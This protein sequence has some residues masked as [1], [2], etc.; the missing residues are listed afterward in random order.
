MQSSVGAELVLTD[1]EGAD[2]YLVR[3]SKN[4]K[5][6]IYFRDKMRKSISVI[7][8]EMKTISNNK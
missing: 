1:I 7:D 6:G 2:V 4:T 5:P 8:E 3:V